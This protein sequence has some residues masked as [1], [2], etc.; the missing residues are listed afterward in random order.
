MD[1]KKGK[2]LVAVDNE[3][4]CT[5]N[6]NCFESMVQLAK[7]CPFW[8]RVEPLI[9]IVPA[10]EEKRMT[11]GEIIGSR[12]YN[13]M[14]NIDDIWGDYH[15]IPQDPVY[16]SG[17]TLKVVLPFYRALGATQKWLY[18]FARSSILAVPDIREVLVSLDVEYDLWMIST[19][20][21]L[22]I[23][24]FCDAV[25]FDSEKAFC[26]KVPSFFAKIPI[27]SE[28]G[29]ALLSFMK[30][31]AL[32]PVIDYSKATGNPV[33]EHRKYYLEITDFIWQQVYGWPIGE[34]LRSVIP[35][36]QAQ[37]KNALV[38]ILERQK[39]V[40]E[41]VIYIG[42]SQT[43]LGIAKFLKG[44][45]LVMMFN[46]KGQV[47]S[48]SDIMYIGKS[49]KAIR[50]VVNCFAVQ[51]RAR[52]IEYYSRP[53]HPDYGGTLSAVTPENIQELEKLSVAM[54]KE[55]RGVHIGSLT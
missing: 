37:K 51:G 38:E 4:P 34:L 48:F 53:R 25:G 10:P 42:D 21:N 9:S 54:R 47:C 23:D 18:K 26:T 12:F 2:I 13:R 15:L 41:N 24:A 32:M 46:G 22:F 27:S 55:F 45:G 33:L 11:L 49:A 40:P 52:T 30:R 14:S 29:Q 28:Q 19:S 6:D 16:S 39:V 50:E 35:I 17:H 44:F 31:V 36:G 8:D 5:K 1:R 43:D 3:G 20:Y 7:A